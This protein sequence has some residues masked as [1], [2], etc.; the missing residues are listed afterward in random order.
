M[1]ANLFGDF[2]KGKDLQ[3]FSEVQKK[4]IIL[5]RAID[6]YIDHH[7]AVIELMNQ[8]Y[9]LLPKVTGIAIDLYFDHLLAKKW[10]TYHTVPLLDFLNKFYEKSI[11]NDPNY[12]SEYK[13]FI[14]KLIHNNWI[15]YYPQFS[16]LEKMSQGVSARISFKNSLEK[17]PEIFLQFE[18]E[19]EMTFIKFMNDAQ[20]YLPKYF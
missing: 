4:G 15:A 13:A 14:V 18:S 6:Q 17:A 9:P 2:V 11:Q 19:I 7:P 10:E 16:S 5:H 20:S 1:Y 3:R 8:L 12:T